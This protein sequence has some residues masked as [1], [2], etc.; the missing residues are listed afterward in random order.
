MGS[1]GFGFAAKPLLCCSSLKIGTHNNKHTFLSCSLPR[2]LFTFWVP[3]SFIAM[4]WRIPVYKTFSE[5]RGSL[6]T[7]GVA[8]A[9]FCAW[10]KVQSSLPSLGE[11]RSSCISTPRRTLVWEEERVWVVWRPLCLSRERKKLKNH[12][13]LVVEH[14]LS[15]ILPREKPP[16]FQKL[17]VQKKKRNVH[18]PTAW[19][20]V[21]SMFCLRLGER[22]VRD[23]WCE[24]YLTG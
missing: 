17:W 19:K 12:E 1:T 7:S 4:A 11:V 13:S 6:R 21:P 3:E 8:R 20:K 16:C 23:E 18:K 22:I 14:L 24:T 2:W 15:P 10:L 5:F 9:F